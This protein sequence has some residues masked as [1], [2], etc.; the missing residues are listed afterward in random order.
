MVGRGVEL[1]VSKGASK[2]REA[3]LEARS[4]TAVDPTGRVAVD[5]VS[6]EVRGGE[7]VA[8]AGVLGNGQTELAQAIMGLLPE[9]G[10]SI[11]VEGHDLAGAS[12]REVLRA[13]VG[14]IPE[15]RIKDG[16]V[17]GFKISENLILDVHDE[18]PYSRGGALNWEVI[19]RTA[20]DRVKEFD[21][22]ASSIE[23]PASTLSGGNQQKV[24]VARELSRSIRLIVAAQPTRGLDVGSIE[25]VHRRLVQARDQGNAVL[26]ISAEL[27]EVLA[28]ADR[29]LVMYRGKLSGPYEAGSLTREEIGLLMAGSKVGVS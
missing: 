25:Y 13:G 6:F 3:V 14:N 15:D 21:I 11:L 28:L 16:L 2:P 27:D 20:R 12:P 26:L 18:I 9:V 19:N 24:I 8:I 1:T 4:L 29:I 17:G 22:R 10:G 23:V 7:I 5:G